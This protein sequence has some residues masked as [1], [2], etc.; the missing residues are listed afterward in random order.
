[1]SERRSKARITLQI[2]PEGSGLYR[3]LVACR[4]DINAVKTTML[5]QKLHHHARSVGWSF[6]QLASFF[7]TTMAPPLHYSCRDKEAGSIGRGF[8]RK[9]RICTWDKRAMTQGF[10][11]NGDRVIREFLDSD[12]NLVSGN[13]HGAR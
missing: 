3:N 11:N 10:G 1:M 6:I 12:E 2:T 9:R 7:T 4:S 5:P 13:L 8:R